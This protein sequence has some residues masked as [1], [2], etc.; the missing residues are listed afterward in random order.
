M[1]CPILETHNIELCGRMFLTLCAMGFTFKVWGVDTSGP[2]ASRRKFFD[3]RS[4]VFV[5]RGGCQKGLSAA[6]LLLGAHPYRCL[7]DLEVRHLRAL[8]VIAEV[9]SLTKAAAR[10]GVSQPGLTAQLARVERLLGGELFFRH[11]DGVTPTAFG[12]MVLERAQAILPGVDDLMHV[13]GPADPDSPVRVGTVNAPLLGGLIAEIRRLF[14]A[15]VTRF[16]V[17]SRPLVE[18]VACGRLDIAI[19][20]DHPGFE[21]PVVREVVYQPIVT[22]PVFALLPSDHRLARAREV[23]LADLAGD[24]WAAPVPDSDRSR[25]YYTLVCRKSA[26]FVPRITHDADGRALS[27]L[28]GWGQAVSVC[29]PTYAERPGVAVRPIAGAPLMYRHLLAWPRGGRLSGYIPDLAR[30]VSAAYRK[31]LRS[32]PVYSAWHGRQ[33]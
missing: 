32:S 31:A 30:A 22:E 27:E 18:L 5:V 21:L 23:S 7:M 12:V 19:V 17:C 25:E 6:V 20:G 3:R 11:P 29:Q 10:L 33:D 16:G 24:P 28:V 13:V 14:P 26:A 4:V 1:Y 9:G 8:S 2:T 15:V